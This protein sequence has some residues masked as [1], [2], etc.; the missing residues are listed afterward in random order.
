MTP[1]GDRQFPAARPA[2]GT[3]LTYTYGKLNEVASVKYG[4][5]GQMRSYTYNSSHDLTGD[6]LITACVHSLKNHRKCQQEERR[7]IMRTLD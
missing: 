2:S 6:T 5:S 1:C 7:G 3:A 4:S